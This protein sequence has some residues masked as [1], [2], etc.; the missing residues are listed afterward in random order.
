MGPTMRRRAGVW[1]IL[2][3]M[4]LV[5]AACGS[6]LVGCD[7]TSEWLQPGE[8]LPGWIYDAPYYY[9]PRPQ[10]ELKARDAGLDGEIPHYYTRETVVPIR[11]P[12]K[13]PANQ[14]PHLAVF[15]SNDHGRHWQKA[16]FFGL[17]QMFFS[18]VATGEGAY[19]IRFA[20]P[21]IEPSRLIDSVAP[22]RVY[23]VDTTAPGVIVQIFPVKQFYE[24]GE[25]VN[26][27][28]TVSD[29]NIDPQAT[30]AV[31]QIAMPNRI[32]PLPAQFPLN[33]STGVI[34]PGAAMEGGV[35]YAVEA[36]DKAGNV[37]RGCSFLIQAPAPAASQPESPREQMHGRPSGPPPGQPPPGTTPAPPAAPAGPPGNTDRLPVVPPP[38]MPLTL[39]PVAPGSVTSPVAGAAPAAP[40]S[41]PLAPA[42]LV[43]E[44]AYRPRLYPTS[45][46][47]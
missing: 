4:L 18:F 12:D 2:G 41:P 20:G 27:S 34:V 42:D 36:T 5:A 16:G 38:A 40:A 26:V 19:S 8:Q 44:P 9:E 15:W 17:D 1:S 37:G 10:N 21:G 22:H 45:S 7:T 14:T 28:W 29:A 3:G 30:V 47:D 35:R 24:P 23:H 33:G 13:S 25:S 46:R 31:Y 32:A 39:P 11:R 6:A 43:V